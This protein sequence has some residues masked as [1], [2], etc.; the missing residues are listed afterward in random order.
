VFSYQR[1]M[2]GGCFNYGHPGAKW[3]C[4]GC[5]G[6]N[7]VFP[8]LGFRP[9]VRVQRVE[10]RTEARHAHTRSFHRPDADRV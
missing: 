9:C 10:S 2:K 5:P 3:D 4:G 7:E 6:L 8:S 1:R